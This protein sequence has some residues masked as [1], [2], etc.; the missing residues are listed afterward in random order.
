MADSRAGGAKL[1]K[2][3]SGLLVKHT[4][5]PPGGGGWGSN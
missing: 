3:G 2:Q 1:R 5:A 4:Q